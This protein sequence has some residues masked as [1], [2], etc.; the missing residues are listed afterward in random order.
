M[1]EEVHPEL[2]RA[3]EEAARVQN[4]VLEDA[5]VEAAVRAN[6][7]RKHMRWAIVAGIVWSFVYTA[8]SLIIMIGVVSEMSDAVDKAQTSC[9][10][11]ADSREIIRTV[12]INS[13]IATEAV[14]FTELP[15][16]EC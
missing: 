11:L 6:R 5:A 3:V 16:I 8:I 13:D 1:R 9:Q 10:N 14:L 15:P 12:L 4:G 7:Q 2:G